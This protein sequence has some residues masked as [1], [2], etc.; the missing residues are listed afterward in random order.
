M[1]NKRIVIF[2]CGYVGRPLAKSL[3]GAGHEVW[4]HSRNVESLGAVEEVPSERKVS[5]NLHES[6]WHGKLSGNWDIAYNLVSSAGGGLDGYRLSYIDG[7]QSIRDWAAGVGVERLIYSSATSVYPQT[8]G[9][10]VSE[11]DVPALEQLS[12]SGQILYEAEQLVLGAPE[13]RS[14]IVARLAG[15]YGP[16]RHLY[17]NRMRE[18]VTAFPGDGNAWLNL[19]Y[20]KDIVTALIGLAEL[21][22]AS[23]VFNV[24]DDSPS[25]KQDIVD[26]LSAE[27]GSAPMRFDPNAAGPRAAR[28]K[29]GVG[30]PNRRVSNAKLKQ[31]LGWTPD[32]PDYQAG[33]RDILSGT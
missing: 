13:F 7:N 12:S 29:S 19:I 18:G 9:E 30:L 26:W 14:R 5:G 1:S 2:G 27:T 6:G 3:A 15:I 11:E 25:R 32:F 24:V 23:D 17:L 33:Y 8:N 4:L 31:Q 21:D 20:L 22:C 28:R 16:G 10:W